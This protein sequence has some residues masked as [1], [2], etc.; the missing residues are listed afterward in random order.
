M[1]FFT[2]AIV[3]LCL[4]TLAFSQESEEVSVTLTEEIVATAHDPPEETAPLLVYAHPRA[5][6]AFQDE[7]GEWHGTQV[8]LLREVDKRMPEDFVIQALPRPSLKDEGIDQTNAHLAIG[9]ITR[10]SERLKNGVPF[11]DGTDRSWMRIGTFWGDGYDSGT[12]FVA[13]FYSFFEAFWHGFRVGHILFIFIISAL[14]AWATKAYADPGKGYVTKGVLTTVLITIFGTFVGSIV[15]TTLRHHSPEELSR[16]FGP[17]DLAY[18]KVAAIEGTPSYDEVAR[19]IMDPDNLVACDSIE[20]MRN[21][22]LDEDND[23]ELMAHEEA[24][25]AWDINKNCPGE[26]RFTGERFGPQFYAWIH[27]SNADPDFVRRL[28][29]AIAQVLEDPSYR[30]RSARSLQIKLDP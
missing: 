13:V 12:G 3:S 14:V 10:S 4:S 5:P 28:N 18:E 2:F 9:A 15:V 20:E 11:T 23:V 24:L 19:W 25:L 16:V 22:V 6:F 1:K 29:I 7:K 8:D 30:E 26:V 27:R 21:L 17:E